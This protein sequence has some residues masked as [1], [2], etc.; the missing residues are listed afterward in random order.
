MVPAAYT[1]GRQS[2]ESKQQSE[3]GVIPTVLARTPVA[4]EPLSLFL[5]RQ[6][7]MARG[8]GGSRTPPPSCLIGNR[9]AHQSACVANPLTHVP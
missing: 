6:P 1:K 7:C 3:A 4:S 2:Q 9:N 8:R 5:N